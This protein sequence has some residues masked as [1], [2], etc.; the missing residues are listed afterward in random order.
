MEDNYSSINFISNSEQTATMNLFVASKLFEGGGSESKQLQRERRRFE[1][2]C[3]LLRRDYRAY[4]GLLDHQKLRSQAYGCLKMIRL[5]QNLPFVYQFRHFDVKS[6]V[7]MN[8]LP[9]ELANLNEL[10]P[11]LD[12][13]HIEAVA[14]QEWVSF[15]HL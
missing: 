11:I 15:T 8:K 5:S 4:D 10:S 7:F 9:Q 13:K 12:K 14:A 3:L 2:N 6:S 1:N